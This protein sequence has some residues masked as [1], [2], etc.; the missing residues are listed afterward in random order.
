[1]CLNKNSTKMHQ[2]FFVRSPTIII[3]VEKR[4]LFLS[5]KQNSVWG[6]SAEYF[7]LT[8]G[9]YSAEMPQTQVPV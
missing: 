5:F 1:M 2:Y 7:N 4:N 9:E 3:F 6:F 8:N